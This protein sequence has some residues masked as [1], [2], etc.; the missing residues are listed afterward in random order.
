MDIQLIDTGFFHAD[1][2]AM[3]GAIPKTAWNRRYPSDDQNGCIL[4]MRSMLVR[5][6][7]G[8]I[9]LVGIRVHPL[10]GYPSL[11]GSFA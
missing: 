4:A 9:V 5:D 10:V 6:E 8:K 1:G 7:S 11:V 2:G 3:F